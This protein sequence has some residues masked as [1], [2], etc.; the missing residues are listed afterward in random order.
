MNWAQALPFGM[1][2]AAARR[3]MRQAHPVARDAK[4]ADA[5]RV[6]V[7]ISALL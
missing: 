7:T 1:K 2:G 3:K 5:A 6:G 4:T